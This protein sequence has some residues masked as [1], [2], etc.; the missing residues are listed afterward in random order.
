[1][2][3]EPESTVEEAVATTRKAL[4]QTSKM[5][6]STFGEPYAVKNPHMVSALIRAQLDY[7]GKV[8]LADA[9]SELADALNKR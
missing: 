6:D 3:I 5:L 7:C 9:I 8:V 1:M 2:Q 4:Q